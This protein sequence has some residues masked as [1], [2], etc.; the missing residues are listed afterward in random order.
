[1]YVAM[2]KN[3]NQDHKAQ[4]EK[5]VH[6]VLAKLGDM[7]YHDTVQGK[8]IYNFFGGRVIEHTTSKGDILAIKVNKGID[9]SEGDI[10]HYAATHGVRAPR[11]R[12]VYDIIGTKWLARAMVSERVPGVP[13]AD[14]WQKL[15]AADMSAIK[16][17]LRT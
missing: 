6:A 5:E 9:R 10:M 7:R 13:L 3:L 1:M 11:V 2:S 16:D 15:G 17:Q 4:E 12:G 14:V 8:E